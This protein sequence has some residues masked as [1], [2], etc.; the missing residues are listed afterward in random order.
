MD[1][2][3]QDIILEKDIYHALADLYNELANE[4]KQSNIEKCNEYYHKKLENLENEHSIIKRSKE[5]DRDKFEN[6]NIADQLDVYLKIADNNF[7]LKNYPE[8]I[9]CLNIVIEKCN[10]GVD[11]TNV[12][13]KIN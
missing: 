2:S 1:V 13:N 4:V 3:F 8:T 11:Q 10:Q 9:K 6:G 12:I 7:K 5:K